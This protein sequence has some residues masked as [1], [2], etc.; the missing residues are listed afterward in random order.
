MLRENDE[1]DANSMTN[2]RNE[3]KKKI[4]KMERENKFIENRCEIIDSKISFKFKATWIGNI[5]LNEFRLF[6]VVFVS[7][8]RNCLNI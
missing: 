8:N 2:E 4:W 3:H 1:H 6:L 7:I 5:H